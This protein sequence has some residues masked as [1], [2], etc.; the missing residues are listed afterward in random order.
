MRVAV[1]SNKRGTTVKEPLPTAQTEPQKSSDKWLYGA[2]AL[3]QVVPPLSILV[4]ASADAAPWDSRKLMTYLYFVTS[5]TLTVYLGSKRGEIKMFDANSEITARNALLAPVLASIILFSL[6][7]LLKISSFQ[8]LFE[9]GYQLLA[10]LIGGLSL[11]SLISLT[12]VNNITSE[13]VSVEQS[14]RE[15]NDVSTSSQGITFAGFIVVAY[16]LASMFIPNPESF[17]VMSVFNNILAT[18]TALLSIGITRVKNFPVA[19]ALLIGLFLYDI[20]F[21]FGTD[22]MM[23]VAT[24]VE[25]PVK[26]LFPASIS[27]IESRPYPFSVLGLGDIVVPGTMASLARRMDIEDLARR[28]KSIN[29]SKEGKIGNFFTKLGYEKSKSSQNLSRIEAEDRV[30]Y[31]DTTLVGYISGLVM[32]FAANEWSKHGQPA[33]LYLVPCVITSMLYASF[34]NKEFN[35][36]WG[37]GLGNFR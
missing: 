33:L 21:V 2:L 15:G 23:T 26:I 13:S 22:I 37:D 3:L 31:L 25:A 24:K 12:I 20:Y 6:Y 19:C 30:S 28:A 29:A 32:A 17:Y 11:D 18:G 27:V 14:M 5:A 36:L 4:D 10:L 35:K 34:R 16:I 1:V 9:K 7:T 8:L